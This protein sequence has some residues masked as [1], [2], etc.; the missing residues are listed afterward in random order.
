[1]DELIEGQYI[2]FELAKEKYALKISD[3]YEITKMKK[4]TVVHN[5]SSYVEGVINLRGKIV[6]VISLH[7]KLKINNYILTKSTRIVILRGIDE[8][9][10]IIVDKVNQV[11]KFSDIQ[12]PPETVAGIEGSYF[13]GLGVNEE[14]VISILKVDQ[15]FYK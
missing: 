10:G 13:E 5:S 6:P 11:T 9:I 2:V 3:V 8:M 4:I 15:V 7:K 14:G 12:A 1:M